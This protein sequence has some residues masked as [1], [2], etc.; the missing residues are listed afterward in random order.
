MHCFMISICD[1]EC[2]FND[3]ANDRYHSLIHDKELKQFKNIWAWKTTAI[4]VT[5]KYIKKHQIPLSLR[6]NKNN[7]S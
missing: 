6:K 5:A 4:K 3:A 2:E 7:K 1:A